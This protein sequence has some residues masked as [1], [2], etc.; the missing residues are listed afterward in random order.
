MECQNFITIINS[1]PP[2][3]SSINN[4][5]N[6]FVDWWLHHH[7]VLTFHT[8]I[9]AIWSDR[10]T[11]DHSPSEINRLSAQQFPPQE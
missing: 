5:I 1:L 11:S 4:T 2:F 9:N 7:L 8:V 6:L 10:V 3:P